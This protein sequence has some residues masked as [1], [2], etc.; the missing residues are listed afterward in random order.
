M[1]RENPEDRSFSESW[2]EPFLEGQVRLFTPQELLLLFGFPPS[3]AFPPS[4]KDKKCLQV[5][6]N[7]LNVEVVKR[8]ILFGFEEYKKRWEENENEEEKEQQN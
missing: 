5:I 1:E 3:F 4:I 8:L 2:F 6:G 7:S